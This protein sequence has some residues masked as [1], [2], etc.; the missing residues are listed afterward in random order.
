MQVKAIAATAPDAPL[1]RTTIERRDVGEHEVLIHTKF[2]GICHSDIHTVRS[3]WG[4]ITYPIVVGHEIAGVVAEVGSGVTKYK[5]G[6][7]VSWKPRATGTSTLRYRYRI[8]DRRRDGG[9]D[10]R[11]TDTWTIVRGDDLVPSATVRATKGADS[12]ARLRFD[13]PPG[14]PNVDTPFRH[15]RDR[16]A[17]VIVN[18]ERRFDRPTGWIIAGDVG[19]RREMIGNTEISV[20]GPK[21]DPVRRNDMLAFFNGLVPQFEAAFGQPLRGL[22]LENRPSNDLKFASSGA[23]ARRKRSGSPSKPRSLPFVRI[24]VA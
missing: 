2:A 5:V 24:S 20:A 15:T 11:I 6:D 21:G 12:R 18:P 1:E 19:T 14:W 4:Q 22:P 23:T 9:Y 8:D 16:N 17:F 3:E 10:A 13:L 7:H